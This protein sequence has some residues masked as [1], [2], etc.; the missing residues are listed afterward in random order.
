MIN[1]YLNE[2]LPDSI[3]ISHPG[4]YQSLLT[5]SLPIACSASPGIPPGKNPPENP[6]GTVHSLQFNE[7]S[8][9]VDQPNVQ[10]TDSNNTVYDS[11]DMLWNTGLTERGEKSNLTAGSPN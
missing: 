6:A 10:S 7:S 8:L 2:E 9:L 1:A 4:L 3:P 5:G 11:A